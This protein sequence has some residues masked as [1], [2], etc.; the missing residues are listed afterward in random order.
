MTGAAPGRSEELRTKVFGERAV[1]DNFWV[2]VT[3]VDIQTPDGERFEHH[4]VRLKTVAIAAVVD[5]RDRVLMLWRY[6]FVTD[7]WGWELPG[8]ISEAGEDAGVTAARE[9][10]EETG[11]RPG[12]LRHLFTFQPMPGMVDTPHALFLARGAEKVAEPTDLE[13][14]GVVDWVPLSRVRELIARGEVLG[15]GSLVAL[16]YLLSG[17]EPAEA[18]TESDGSE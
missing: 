5:E 3:L 11:W 12:P 1:Y 17:G 6:R 18:A 4:V 9:V 15:S 8:G 14:A 16:L 13:E 10:L 7:E 2:R